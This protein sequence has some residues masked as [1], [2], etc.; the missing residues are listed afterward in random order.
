MDE[1]EGER[2]RR[3]Y[4]EVLSKIS[5]NLDAIKIVLGFALILAIYMTLKW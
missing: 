2:F 1:S 4:L 3:E 5:S